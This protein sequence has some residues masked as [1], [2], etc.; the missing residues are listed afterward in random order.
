M[1]HLSINLKLAREINESRNLLDV[2]LKELK[3]CR[4]EQIEIKSLIYELNSGLKPK[5][6]K[7][8]TK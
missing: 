8:E 6:N 7:K 1:E 2:I 4:Q 3:E 5:P